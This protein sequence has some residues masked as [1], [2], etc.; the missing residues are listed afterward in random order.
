MKRGTIRRE[1]RGE[2][3]FQ[4]LKRTASEALHTYFT[5]VRLL[6]VGVAWGVRYVTRLL[7]GRTKDDPNAGREARVRSRG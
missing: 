7:F 3:T 1:E 5:P 6:F 4:S 2:I